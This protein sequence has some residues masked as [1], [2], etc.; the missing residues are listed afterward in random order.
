MPSVTRNE[1][2]RRRVTNQP[3]TKPMPTA[4]I[5]DSTMASSSPMTFWL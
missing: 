2:I 3:L 1:G 4:T 5:S